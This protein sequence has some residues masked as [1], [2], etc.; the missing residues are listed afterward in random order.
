MHSNRDIVYIVEVDLI[1]FDF[2]FF[3]M[4]FSLIMA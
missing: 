1:P 3:T 4:H 2:A